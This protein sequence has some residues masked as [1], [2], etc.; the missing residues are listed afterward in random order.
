MLKAIWTC[1]LCG[2][3]GETDQLEETEAGR[4]VCPKCHERDNL[5]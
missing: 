4:K 3:S 5:E 2:W 1:T